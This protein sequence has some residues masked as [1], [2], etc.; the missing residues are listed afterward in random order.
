MDRT[1]NLTR[2]AFCAI[3]KPVSKL[4]ESM[5]DIPERGQMEK[6][7]KEVGIQTVVH[8]YLGEWKQLEER[9]G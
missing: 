2:K 3:I 8:I 4:Q 9:R 6:A 7:I 1:W 5:S